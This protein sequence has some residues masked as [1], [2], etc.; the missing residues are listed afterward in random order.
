MVEIFKTNVQKNKQAIA[1]TALLSD[2]F[3]HHIIRFDLEDCDKILRVEGHAVNP[4][5]IVA[6]MQAQGYQCEILL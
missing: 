3:A 2:T 6:L 1:L 4:S 5:A